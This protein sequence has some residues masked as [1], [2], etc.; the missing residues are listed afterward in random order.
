MSWTFSGTDPWV[1][2]VRDI[3]CFCVGLWLIVQEELHH[4]GRTILVT[5][6]LAL[7]GLPLAVRMK[8]LLSGLFNKED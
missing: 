7:C 8:G 1:K 4:G 6:A 5:A 2:L 3:L